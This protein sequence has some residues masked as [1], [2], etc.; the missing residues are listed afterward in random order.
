MDS[1]LSILHRHEHYY[2]FPLFMTGSTDMMA[3]MLNIMLRNV[4]LGSCYQPSDKTK[5]TLC[6]ASQQAGFYVLSYLRVQ[7]F[8][9]ATGFDSKTPSLVQRG[10]L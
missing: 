9:L 8:H 5:E 7:D 1:G 10:Y 3:A 6:N 2:S 4:V